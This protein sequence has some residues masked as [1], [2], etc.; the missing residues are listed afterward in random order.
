MPEP[1]Q[2]T[3]LFVDIGGVLLTDGWNHQSRQAA[4]KK[5]GLDYA[6]MDA[7]H[8][9]MFDTYEAGKL[10][11]QEYL[12]RCVFYED[13]PFTRDQFRDFMF[14][15]S[16]P[17][18][19][20][21]ALIAGLKAQFGLKI[22]AVSNEARELNDYRIQTFKLSTLIDFFVSSCYVHLRKPD[23]E[24]FRLA[25]DLSQTPVEQIVYI[26]N[27]AMFV[28]IA[29]ELGI[30]SILHTDS[31]STCARL[32]EFGLQTENETEK[33]AVHGGH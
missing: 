21:I 19:E 29:E 12:D 9:K 3:T 14:A 8:R 13:R 31:N 23:R 6:E 18:P 4:A 5:F 16:Q 24:I 32:A 28:D 30:R 10:S 25:L 20:M 26:E 2:I 33:E 1:T 7:R 17:Y 27:T 15:Q 11:L 22:A